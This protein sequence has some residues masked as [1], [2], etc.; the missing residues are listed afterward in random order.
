MP[1]KTKLDEQTLLK[2]VSLQHALGQPELSSSRLVELTGA[3][4]STVKRVLERLCDAGQLIR[5]GRARATRYRLPATYAHPANQPPGSFVAEPEP[6]ET[7]P[8]L[9]WSAA[10]EDLRRKLGAPLGS[11][12]PV[13]YKREFVDRYVPNESSLLPL[14]LARDLAWPGRMR[15]ASSPREPMPARCWN[16][17]SSTSRGPRP[18]WKATAIPGSIPSNSSRAA[19]AGRTATPSCCSTTRTR[20]EFMVDA[21]PEQGLTM[22][23]VRNLHAVLLHETCWPTAHSLGAMRQKVVNI[24]DTVYLPTQVPSLLSE[25]LERVL[26][27]ARL[28]KNPVESAFFL[29]RQHRLPPAVRGRQ[30]AH[31]PAVRQQLPPDALPAPRSAA[32]SCIGTERDSTPMRMLGAYELRTRRTA[33]RSAFDW[34]RYPGLEVLEQGELVVRR[35]D[36]AELVAIRDGAMSYDALVVEAEQLQERMRASFEATSLPA[37]VDYAA[38]DAL[39]LAV[40]ADVQSVTA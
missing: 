14:D 33:M 16:S 9:R 22:S 18:A 1:A 7:T 12:E 24:S 20:I 8:S 40:L 31:E 11:R 37:D 28:I 25:M 3:G 35:P 39:L 2:L 15:R 23:L 34:M 4:A 17:C 27:K 30:Q 29:W 21:V 26:R 36:A 6:G 38:V 5:S 32:R 19:W 10:A 13:T